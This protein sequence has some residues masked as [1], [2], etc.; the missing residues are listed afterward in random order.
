MENLPTGLEEKK[1]M[2]K[3]SFKTKLIIVLAIAAFLLLA[4]GYYWHSS[5]QKLRVNAR[6]VLE[7]AQKYDDLKAK[8]QAE[9]SRCENFIS[10]QKGD[11][12]SFEYCQKFIEWA[13][14]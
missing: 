12:G 6:A 4:Y 9:Q 8:I 5:T 13:E 2:K 3:S 10:Q 7:Q 1:P 14:E 11:F